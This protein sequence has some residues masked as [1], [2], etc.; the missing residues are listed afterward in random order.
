MEI[1][2]IG[3]SIVH[4]LARHLVLYNVLCVSK[5]NKNLASVHKLAK[6]NNAFFEFHPDYFF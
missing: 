6:D 5:A 2:Q 1:K 3:H 4:A